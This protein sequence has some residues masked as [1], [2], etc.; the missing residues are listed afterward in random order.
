MDKPKRR[1]TLTLQLHADSVKQLRADLK[2][3]AFHIC[4]EGHRGDCTSGGCDSGYHYNVT[5]RP[6]ITPEKYREKL[7]AYLEEEKKKETP[8]G[9]LQQSHPDGK[10][11]P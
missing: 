2:E 3:I 10:S 4:D 7:M 8:S 6:E 11:N 9:Q 5:E 1:F